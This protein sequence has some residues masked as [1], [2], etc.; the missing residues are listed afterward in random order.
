MSNNI[1]KFLIAVYGI[2]IISAVFEK[3]W[4]RIEYFLGAMLIS[5]SI[6]KGL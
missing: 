6:L 3:N 5:H 2:I 1:L 4:N